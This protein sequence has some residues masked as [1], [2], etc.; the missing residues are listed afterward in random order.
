MKKKPFYA[1]IRIIWLL[2]GCLSLPVHSSA[3]ALKSS[4]M[5]SVRELSIPPKAHQ[6]FE[7][8]IE[9]LAKNDAAESLPHFQRAVAKF[10][11]YY[12]SYYEMGVAYWK[13]ERIADAEQAYRNSIELSSGLYTWSLVALG[14]VLN[15]QE[16]YI[17][18]EEVLR[19][20]LEL[21]PTSWYGHFY[22]GWTLF[23]LNRLEEAEKNVREALSQ[24]TNSRET[25][26]LLADIHIREKDYRAVVQ[27]LDKYLKLDPDSPNAVIAKTVRG[28]AQKALLESENTRKLAQ[29][30]P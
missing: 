5:V 18:A 11:S 25:L 12:E 9:L 27:D 10:A 21:D 13:L 28:N 6:E 8:G 24:E 22:L 17:E 16:K 14:A 2:V 4:N 1:G 26:W 29:P 30:Q 3:Q 7:H 23:G 19:R 20:D 15:Y